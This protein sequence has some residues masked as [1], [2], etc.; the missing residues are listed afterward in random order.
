MVVLLV[1]N[2]NEGV[3]NKNCEVFNYKNMYVIDGSIIPAN[4]GVNPS[5]TITAMAEMAMD[6]ISYK[7]I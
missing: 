2:E 7:L 3:I 5:L 1:D 4:L 6:K